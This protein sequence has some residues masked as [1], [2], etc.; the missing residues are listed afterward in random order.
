MRLV[1]ERIFPNV[2]CYAL[3]PHLKIRPKTLFN[4]WKMEKKFGTTVFLLFGIYMHASVV[5][6]LVLLLQ[7]PVALV[8]H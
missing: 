3:I 4:W 6:S 1:N 5:A 2:M 8:A 7:L